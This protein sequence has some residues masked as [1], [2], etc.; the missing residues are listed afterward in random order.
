MIKQARS[1]TKEKGRLWESVKQE[2]N[3][4]ESSRTYGGVFKYL[5][6]L[7][8]NIQTIPQVSRIIIQ[9]VHQIVEENKK[10][11]E[12]RKN[13]VEWFHIKLKQLLPF[14]KSERGLV[15]HIHS[16][17]K[18]EIIDF[19]PQG[20][21]GCLLH[22]LRHA[23]VEM[24]KNTTTYSLFEGWTLIDQVDS[25]E[26]HI[27]EFI[28]PDYVA[29]EI[30]RSSLEKE[31]AQ[32]KEKMDVSLSDLYRFLKI[33]T[34]YD[35]FVP[36]TLNP[37]PSSCVSIKNLQEVERRQNQAHIG[38]YLSLFKSLEVIKHPLTIDEIRRLITHFIN[39]L[40]GEIGFS[41]TIMENREPLI[42]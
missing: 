17:L 26:F 16:L 19:S 3:L 32:Y 37:A 25:D 21:L 14:L 33:L 20:Y 23:A 29:K 22:S 28:F 18:F 38:Y 36:L 9:I 31:L 6:Q 8:K 42:T 39:M 35:S 7:L 10:A 11:F 40:E 27:R 41:A 30:N 15:D 12:N 2:F 5:K 4:I 13:A 34:L 1:S 24:V